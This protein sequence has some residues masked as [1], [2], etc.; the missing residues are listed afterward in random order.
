M[1]SW[2]IIV[3]MVSRVQTGRSP[4]GA[5]HRALWRGAG[6]EG[7]EPREVIGL[8]TWR[9]SSA[10]TWNNTEKLETHVVDTIKFIG[11]WCNMHWFVAES[12]VFR[13]FSIK[14]SEKTSSI[15]VIALH[16]TKMYLQNPWD[17]WPAR[18]VATIKTR[19]RFMWE[20]VIVPISWQ[21]ILSNWTY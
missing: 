11:T 5:P 14:F 19:N 9:F 21:V 20:E 2:A 15:W 13:F 17:Q 18:L 1:L 6:T 4:L 12:R 16:L 8:V 10:M 7:R 3:M